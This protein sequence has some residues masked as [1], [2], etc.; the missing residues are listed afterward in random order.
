MAHEK[1]RQTDGAERDL[2]GLVRLTLWHTKNAARRPPF[3]RRTEES[4]W[5]PTNGLPGWVFP[6]KVCGCY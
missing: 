5:L 4:V 6:N 2:L 3:C 1:R